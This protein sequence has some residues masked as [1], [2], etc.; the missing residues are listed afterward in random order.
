MRLNLFP[1]VLP[2]LTKRRDV[3]HNHG[4]AVLDDFGRDVPDGLVT[5]TFFRKPDAANIGR[6]VFRRKS[7]TF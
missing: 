4:A 5:E 2:V 7:Q 6:P 1:V 3:R